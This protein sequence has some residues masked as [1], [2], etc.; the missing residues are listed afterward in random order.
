M[1]H[2]HKNK[3][4]V[5][6]RKDALT[7]L[8]ISDEEIEKALRDA[9]GY[10]NKAAILLKVSRYWLSSRIKKSPHLTS[11]KDD[12]MECRID[13]YE[14]QL[15]ECMKKHDVAAIIFFLKTVGK[16]RGYTQELLTESNLS[17]IKAFMDSN[18]DPAQQPNTNGPLAQ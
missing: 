12:L 11:L 5:Y 7:K 2:P 8:E 1:T 13:D 15:D 18:R 10:Q 3:P 4:R 17:A 16:K 9:K 14:Q 6:R